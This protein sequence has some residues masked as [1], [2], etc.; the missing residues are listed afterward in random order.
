MKDIIE[1]WLRTALL[2]LNGKLVSID[3]I[4]ELSDT[5]A[6]FQREWSFEL[7]TD[8]WISFKSEEADVRV[9][10]ANKEIPIH[11]CLVEIPWEF[12]TAL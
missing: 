6:S 5:L 7:L 12:R 8:I 4:L 11:I 9:K 1:H 3:E 2:Q 10:I